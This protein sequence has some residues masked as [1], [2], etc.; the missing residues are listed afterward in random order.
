MRD[1]IPFLLCLVVL[2]GCAPRTVLTPEEFTEEYAAEMRKAFPEMKIVVKGDKELAISDA[3]GNERQ[4]FLDNCYREYCATPAE[5]AAIMRKFLAAFGE[6][7]AVKDSIDPARIT[8]VLKDRAWVGEIQATLA[9]RGKHQHPELVYADLNAELV[10]VYAEDSPK[11]LRYLTPKELEA[12]KLTKN[13]LRALAVR[14]LRALLPKL[15]ITGNDGRYMITADGTYEASLLLLDELWTGEKMTV[16]GEF[17]VAL[18]ARDLLLVTGSRNKEG[19]AR[20]QEIA[21]KTVAEGSYRLT[22]D[23]FIRRNGRFEKFVP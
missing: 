2:A 16:E 3:A 14:K 13:D 17:V 19:L 10:V 8:P 21:H 5:K 23:L 1:I 18:P 11:N 22:E 20:L 15:E 6:M 9:G 7:G 4:S 12:A